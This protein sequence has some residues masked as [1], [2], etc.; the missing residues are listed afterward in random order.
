MS[1]NFIKQTTYH[2]SLTKP[3]LQVSGH[4][5]AKLYKKKKKKKKKNRPLSLSDTT[6]PMVKNSQT[7]TDSVHLKTPLKHNS[8]STTHSYTTLWMTSKP[9]K[10]P[11]PR[12]VITQKETTIFIYR[13][14]PTVS[15]TS[16]TRTGK[17]NT[18]NLILINIQ[19]YQR[20]RRLIH[21]YSSRHCA[22]PA[23]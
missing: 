1:P 22:Q 19:S 2:N 3:N 14:I 11:G 21:K 9:H 5:K 10:Y 12:L 8:F 7:F 16:Q 17:I 18:T 13:K 4:P 15:M 23:Q 6:G 20:L